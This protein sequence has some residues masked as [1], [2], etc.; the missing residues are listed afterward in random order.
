MGAGIL[1]VA[2]YRGSIYILL[3]QE[4]YN[5]Q[6]SDF[7]GGALPNE[8]RDRYATAIRE[9]SEELN[10]LFGVSCE[11]RDIVKDNLLMT[12]S[13]TDDRYT[14][15]VYR[16]DYDKMLPVYFDRQNRFIETH[17]NDKIYQDNGLFEKSRIKWF[18][19]SE[20]LNKNTRPNI[21]NFYQCIID[22]VVKSDK[23][24]LK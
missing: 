6:W 15:Y 24:L 20:L 4:R 19:H 1:P 11:L 7:G 10:G 21:R 18:K 5:G 14:S 16:V 17:L 8:K 2:I 13:N 9:G 12:I 3:G 22:K 23:L